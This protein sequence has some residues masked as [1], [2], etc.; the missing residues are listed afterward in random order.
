VG[1][2]GPLRV[3]LGTA[4]ILVSSTLAATATASDASSP[5]AKTQMKAPCA[6]ADVLEKL[7]RTAAAQKAY[8]K[9]LEENPSAPCAKRGLAA[10]G[11]GAECATADALL[12]GGD[13]AEAKKAYIETLKAMPASDCGASGLGKTTDP[14]IWEDFEAVSSDALGAIG[15]GVLVLAALAVAFLILANTLGRYPP[16]E[17]RWPMARIRRPTVSVEPLDDTGLKDHKLGIAVAALIKERVE[18]STGGDTLKLVSGTTA[19]EETSIDR[20]SRIGDQGKIAAAVIGLLLSLLPRRHVKVSGQ[21][22]PAAEPTGPGIGLELHGK[23]ESKGSA[24]FWASQFLLPSGEGVETVRRLA[25]PAAAWVSH[26]VTEETGEKA[27]GS[28]DPTSWALFRAAVERQWEGDF[29]PARRLYLEALA[30][31]RK[32]YGAFVNLGFL[33]AAAGQYETAIELLENALE[34]LQKTVGEIPSN[35]D[36]YRVKYSLATQRVNWALVEKKEAQMARGEDEARS[37][38]TT[39]HDRLSREREDGDDAERALDAFLDDDL[40]PSLLVLFAGIELSK[41][42]RSRTVSTPNDESEDLDRLEE[43]IRTGERVDPFLLVEK[44]VAKYKRP[45]PGLSYNLACFYAQ[46]GD[47]RSALQHLHKTVEATPPSAWP[48][49]RAEI[50]HDPMLTQ[51]RGKVENLFRDEPAPAAEPW[52]ARIFELI[53]RRPLA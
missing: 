26:K 20:V 34:I 53:S 14:T 32:N 16:F 30:Y 35:P 10:L 13:D 37:L 33:E 18:P 23:L 44:V 9:E 41:S 22:H 46:A 31:D 25:V 24:T 6:Q 48:Q 45:S 47:P 8:E 7:G 4:L 43:R 27:T 52:I 29:E 40:K 2:R 3:A 28:A 5:S 39:V 42:D 17:S 51:L 49:L 38:L 15:F 12:A 11:E 21:L 50:E 1:P 36:W 19:T